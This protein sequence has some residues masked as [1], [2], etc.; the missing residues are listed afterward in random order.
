MPDQPITKKEHLKMSYDILKEEG[1]LESKFSLAKV[2]P[3]LFRDL[4]YTC[5]VGTDVLKPMS[6]EVEAS[7][8]LQTYDRMVQA[9]NLFDPQETAKLLLKTSPTTQK[10]PDK[11]IAKQPQ[12][13]QPQN[14]LQQGA[15]Q[16]QQQL[17]P[18]QPQQPVQQ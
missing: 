7:W 16:K 6:E 12:G 13:G 18:S 8:N 1:G 10:H 9:P 4:K 17:I 11:Y 14:A 2:N 5:Y 3:A 15:L